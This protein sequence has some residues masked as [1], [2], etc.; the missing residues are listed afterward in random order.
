[1]ATVPGVVTEDARKYWPQLIGTI[2]IPATTTNTGATQWDPRIKTF[3]VG[4]GGW[5]NPGGGA[6]P[7]TPS[8]SLRRLTAPLIQDLDAVV[9]PTRALVDQRYPAQSLATFSKALTPG[10]FLFESPSII[11]VRCLL[12]F[13][14]FNNDGFANSP[15]I[16]EIGL[17]SD[18]PTE[19]GQSLM[20]A[21]AT[22][23]MQIKDNSKQLENLIRIVF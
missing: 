2:F 12:D 18:H 10:D 21:Y 9:D 13:A 1:M 14:E 22:F 11:R 15:E 8:P 17:F 16:Y 3:K 6:V 23:P 5:I 7:R 19:A 20:V 4:E